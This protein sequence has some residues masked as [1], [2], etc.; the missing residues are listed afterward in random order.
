MS[1]TFGA[2][3]FV[4]DVVCVAE[5]QPVDTKVTVKVYVPAP[6]LDIVA[7]PLALVV[8]ATAAAPFNE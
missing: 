3:G 6:K 4:N 8:T 1:F 7:C 5:T 2:P